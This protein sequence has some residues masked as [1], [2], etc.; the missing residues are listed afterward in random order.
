MFDRHSNLVN[1]RW[2]EIESSQLASNCDISVAFN[3]IRFLAS[4]GGMFPEPNAFFWP[5]RAGQQVTKSPN[6]LRQYIPP[7]HSTLACMVPSAS[8]KTYFDN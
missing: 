2:R 7:P 3:W 4:M 8:G 5:L 1:G 6:A